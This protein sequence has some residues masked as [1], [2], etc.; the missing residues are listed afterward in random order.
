MTTS[1]SQES[2]HLTQCIGTTGCGEVPPAD[3]GASLRLLLC[4]DVSICDE[5]EDCVSMDPVALLCVSLA[6]SPVFGGGSGGVDDCLQIFYNSG[7]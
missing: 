7:R 2:L 3:G 1:K 5:F 4:V 6:L